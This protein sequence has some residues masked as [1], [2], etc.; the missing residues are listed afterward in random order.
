MSLY[1]ALLA[2]HVL[3]AVTW[4][5]SNI[6]NNILGA[7]RLR[8]ASDADKVA[9]ARELEWYGNH[10]LVPATLLLLLSG[11]G[12]VAEGDLSL[13]EPW[14]VIALAGWCISFVLGAGFAGPQLKRFFTEVEAAG[15]TLTAGSTA[16]MQRILLVA[17]IEVAM[18]VLIVIDMVVKPG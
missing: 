16:R 13:G 4:V 5:G 6:A 15:N 14:I 9:L 18:L 7:R 8:T 3:M 10:V 1:D 17:R 2:L 11:F 12:I